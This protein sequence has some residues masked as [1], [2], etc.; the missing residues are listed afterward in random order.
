MPRKK[1]SSP[2]YFSTKAADRAVAFFEEWLC[3]VKGEWAGQPFLLEPWEREIVRRLFGW[4]RRSDGTRRYRKCYVEIPRKNGKSLLA[5][6]IALYCL[7]ADR[8]PGAEVYSAATN[9]DQAGMVFNPA[10]GMVEA[11]PLLL[12]AC[13]DG[14]VLRRMIRVASTGNVYQVLSADVPGKHGLNA[15]AVIVDE[16]HAHKD[17]DF[18]DVL[19]TSQGT[20]RQ[21]ILFMITTAGWDRNSICWEEHQYARGVLDGT[22]DDPEYLAVIYAAPADADWDDPKIWAAANPNLGVSVKLEFLEAEA[23]KARNTPGYVNVF[24][25]LYLNQWTEAAARWLSMRKWNRCAASPPEALAG[26]RCWGGLDLSSTLDLTAYA[27]LFLDEKQIADA[28]L[29]FFV[30]EENL[31]ERV[32]RD[33]VP[34]NRWRDDGWITCTPGNVVDYDMIRETIGD[35]AEQYDVQEVGYDRW[36]STQLTTQLDSDG[37]TMA[38]VGQGWRDMSS[39]SKELERR[40]VS[41]KIRHGGNPVLAWCARNVC[42]QQDPAGNMK[43][44]KKRSHERID[45]I[46]ALIIAL[47]RAMVQPENKP[48]VYESR[49][50]VTV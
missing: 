41:G 27:L 10:K 50:I 32:K 14:K 12:E 11:N 46:V 40:I 33:K 29:W 16:L 35:S 4:H 2:Y 7:F 20:R 44:D 17:R 45:G 5:A 36:N 28:L 22:V 31:I 23:V 24:R 3:H 9:R 49:G 21:P 6:G 39:P 13:E 48:S 38:K 25:R 26:R 30:P 1:P 42:V 18:L 19:R 8:E 43:P 15:H 47:A 34:Y 37:I